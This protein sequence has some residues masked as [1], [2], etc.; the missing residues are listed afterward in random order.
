MV[1]DRE[2][3]QRITEIKL[4]GFR[5][6]AEDLPVGRLREQFLSVA[7]EYD[8]L[9]DSIERQFAIPTRAAL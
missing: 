9:A 1:E 3:V 2:H 4:S 5:E 8:E 6:V 7:G